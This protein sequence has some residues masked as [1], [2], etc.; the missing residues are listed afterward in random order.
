[1]KIPMFKCQV[2]T[3]HLYPLPSGERVRVRG[4]LEFDIG[5][6]TFEGREVDECYLD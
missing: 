2:K 5:I 6:L 1:M 3:P 4:G